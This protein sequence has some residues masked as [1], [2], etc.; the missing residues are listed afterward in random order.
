M[1]TVSVG[2]VLCLNIGID[3][4]DIIKP[5]P[6]AVLQS[7]TDPFASAAS[8]ASDTI[9]NNLTKQYERLK[10]RP[11]YKHLIDPTIEDV[12][13]LC[14]SLRKKSKEER[15]L[16]VITDVTKIVADVL[17]SN[18]LL[19]MARRSRLIINW[20]GPY[21]HYE[22]PVVQACV[23]AGSEGYKINTGTLNSVINGYRTMNQLRAIRRR[24]YAEVLTKK[25]PKS[26]TILKRKI[27]PFTRSEIVG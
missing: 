25:I 5:I 27:A 1:K 16:F 20:V 15:V 18:S 8:K 14:T 12:K 23:D 10:S 3:P 22:R 19:E 4:P 26:R 9:A 21:C 17:N 11:C 24:L 13:K 7:W 2:V 6:H